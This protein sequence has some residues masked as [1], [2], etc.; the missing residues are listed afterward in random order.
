MALRFANMSQA[1]YK[2]STRLYRSNVL[3]DES[4]IREWAYCILEGN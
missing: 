4:F 1:L 2:K 3:R